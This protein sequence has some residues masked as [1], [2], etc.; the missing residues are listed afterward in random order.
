[1][2]RA[3]ATASE[4]SMDLSKMRCIRCGLVGMAEATTTVVQQLDGVKVTI[5]GVPSW[6]CQSCGEMTLTGTVMIPIDE[7]IEQIFFAAGVAVPAEPEEEAVLRAENRALAR[8]LGQEDTLVDN[9]DETP[10]GEPSSAGTR[11]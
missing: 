9:L 10:V 11:S 5:D 4:V 6:Q 3:A 7:A 2:G 1:M 8:A